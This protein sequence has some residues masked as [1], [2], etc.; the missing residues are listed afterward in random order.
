VDEDEFE[1]E[2]F[3]DEPEHEG[4]DHEDAWA[5][6]EPPRPPPRARPRSPQPDAVRRRRITAGAVIAGV[7]LFVILLVV[8][9]SGG[10]GGGAGGSYQGYLTGLSPVA[11]N[12]QQTGGS[13]ADELAAAKTASARNGLVGKLDGLASDATDQLHGLEALKTPATLTS[14]Q[15]QALAALDLRLRGLQGLRDAVSQGLANPGDTSWNAVAQ[16]QLDDLMT[17][18]VLWDGA[19]TSANGVLQAHGGGFFPPSRFVADPAGL[20]TSVRT[21]L[22]GG[23]GGGGVSSNGP[24]LSLGSSGTDVAAWQNGLNQWLKKTGSTEALTADGNFGANTQT[25]TEQLQSAAGLTPDGVVGAS[26]RQALQAAL[27]GKSSSGQTTPTSAALKLGASGAAV[28][29]WQNQLNQ[30]LKVNAPTQTQLTV[31]G[32]FGSSTQTATEQFQSASGLTPTGQ[33]DSATQHAMA[34]ALSKTG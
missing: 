33:V 22:G 14:Q 20:Q 8:L 23:S 1:F 34:T 13:L 30:W 32:S 9:T 27:S 3:P 26:T 4:E 15:A 2:F 25:V 10:G 16:A 11:A 29:A 21:A 18:D 19:R 12:S 5:E 6:N 28:T 31:D 7:I 24:N 17:S